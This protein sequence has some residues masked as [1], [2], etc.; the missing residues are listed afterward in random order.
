MLNIKRDHPKNRDYLFQLLLKVNQTARTC[1]FNHIYI[2]LLSFLH[3]SCKHFNYIQR[4]LVAQRSLVV[5]R[6]LK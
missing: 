4:S 6:A 3:Q 2:Q 1:F 5:Q